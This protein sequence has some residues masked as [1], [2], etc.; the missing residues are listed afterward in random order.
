MNWEASD[1]LCCHICLTVM[2]W[3]QICTN[4]KCNSLHLILNLV[5]RP[6]SRQEHLFHTWRMMVWVS[7]VNGKP[8]IAVIALLFMF[9]VVFYNTFFFSIVMIHMFH[10]LYCSSFIIWLQCFVVINNAVF[11]YVFLGTHMQDIL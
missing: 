6:Q 11:L 9:K 8:S 4:S 3:N 10:L 7:P 1:W 2:I 5:I